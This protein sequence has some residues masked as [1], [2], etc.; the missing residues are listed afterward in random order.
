MVPV[1]FFIN[2]GRRVLAA[3]VP[4]LP[5]GS[6]DKIFATPTYVAFFPE[7]RPLE[8][9]INEMTARIHLLP[10]AVTSCVL[11]LFKAHPKSNWP[12]GS[13]LFE[14]CAAYRKQLDDRCRSS[15]REPELIW[16]DWLNQTRRA[17]A[18]AFPSICPYSIFPDAK[19]SRLNGLAPQLAKDCRILG[20]NETIWLPK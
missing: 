5:L 20:A 11:G 12:K 4:Q 1:R 17:L 2:G 10:F 9:K 13:A 8:I 3:E 7:K 14:K 16:S 15:A 6:E 18:S 19:K